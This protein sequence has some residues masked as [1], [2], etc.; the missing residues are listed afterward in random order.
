MKSRSSM[1]TV[2]SIVLALALPIISATTTQ[3]V[4]VVTDPVGFIKLEAV[5]TNGL[6]TTTALS[7]WGL[8]LTQVVTNQ[9]IITSVAGT[10]LT[11]NNPLSPAAFNRNIT[12]I[13][14]NPTAFIEIT[15]GDYAG[16]LDDIVSNDTSAVYTDNDLS[17][18]L[19]GG[20]T[21]KIRPHWT[22]ASVFGP[23]NE[24][25]LKPGT[26][27]GNADNVNVWNPLTQG[28]T[29]YYYKTNTGGG[30][31]GWRSGTSASAN[32]AYTALYI[33]QGIVIRR[34]MGTATNVT[35]VGQVKLGPTITPI[36]Q[37]GVTFAANMYAAP[38]TLGNSG[39]YTTNSNTGIK[40]GTS[41]GNADNVN[42]WNPLTQGY[43]TYYYKTNTGG[44]GV[45][46]RSG[47]SASID[48]STNQIPLG[49]TIVIRRRLDTPF[50]WY[51]PPAYTNQ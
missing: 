11:V 17:S 34:R 33:D 16:L 42:I 39:L 28:Y 48:A 2:V 43:A 9:G 14:T 24:A 31:V 32:A 18:L 49:A 47:T 13:Y 51:I 15:S 23:N 21:Y 29:T 40:P 5:G 41:A 10:K 27:A 35:L 1:R 26:G 37:S 25:G 8:G 4:D 36:V 22:L 7:F 38:F 44:G 20:E 50:N 6:A 45:G 19:S 46:W 12:S 3:A 30:G